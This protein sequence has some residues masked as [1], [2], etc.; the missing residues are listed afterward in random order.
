MSKDIKKILITTDN[1]TAIWTYTIELLR[2]F[3]DKGIQTALAIMGSAVTADQKDQLSSFKNV[4]PY[5]GDFKLEW[6]EDPWEDIDEAGEWL[7]NIKDEFHPDLIHLNSFS[8]GALNWGIPVVTAAHTELISLWKTVIK[9][10][11]PKRLNEYFKRVKFGLENSS[12][13]VAPSKS[14]MKHLNDIYGIFKNQRIIYNGRYFPARISG[15]R[16]EIIF[17]MG[18]IWDTAKNI[19]MVVNTAPMMKWK[20]QLA[21][22]LVNPLS[23]EISDQSNIELLGNLT[24]GQVFEHLSAASI[25]VLPA[26]YEPFGF[27]PLEAALSGCAL[28]LGDIESLREIWEDSAVYVDPEDAGLLVEKINNLIDNPALM[29]KYSKKAY[30]KACEYKAEKMFSEYMN[31]YYSFFG[32]NDIAV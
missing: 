22:N 16:E 17:S 19:S 5:Y 7:L 29:R 11:Y 30:K 26:K 13:I 8:F 2:G 31:V 1:I 6:M 21:G 18:R 23:E 4:I 3:D 28:V 9:L 10:P 32:G 25:F 24:P 12:I 14:M 20:V 15:K 27:S